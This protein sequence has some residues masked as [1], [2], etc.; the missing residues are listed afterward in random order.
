[1]NTPAFDVPALYVQA[2]ALREGLTT[3]MLVFAANTRGPGES[4]D[5]WSHRCWI[6]E[7]RGLSV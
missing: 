2:E 3:R 7:I 1:M 4:L 5:D 6:S